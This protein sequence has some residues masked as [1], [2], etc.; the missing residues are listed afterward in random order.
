LNRKTAALAGA[1]ARP[2]LSWRCAIV[3][4]GVLALAMWGC[5]QQE[6]MEL[7]LACGINALR[8]EQHL[9]P[10]PVD[11]ALSAVARMRAEDMA[12]KGY[13]SHDPPDGC[14]LRC[15]LERHRIPVAWTGETI[16]WNTYQPGQSVLATVQMWKNSPTHYAVITGCHFTRVGVGAATGA[17]GRT[18]DVAVF[19]GDEDGCPP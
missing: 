17:D 5:T 4:C 11:P 15:L 3:L 16:A 12:S 18:F 6:A 10:L 19:E 9:A 13:F 8:T 1:F 14:N 7:Q 2:L